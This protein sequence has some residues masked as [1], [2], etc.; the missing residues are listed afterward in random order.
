MGERNEAA[1][2]IQCFCRDS[3]VREKSD[4]A[5]NTISRLRHHLQAYARRVRD[6][7]NLPNVS[8]PSLPRQQL[9]PSSFHHAMD[10]REGASQP[11]CAVPFTAQGLT[12][13]KVPHRSNCAVPFTAQ[14]LTFEK[15][16]HSHNCAVPFTAQGLTFEKV[17][18]SRLVQCH[19]QLKGYCTD[20]HCCR[21]ADLVLAQCAEAISRH[22]PAR[23]HRWLRGDLNAREMT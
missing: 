17:P 19:S 5:G 1:T 8:P 20:G 13:E 21:A 3:R 11:P 15:V 12:F 6:S 2:E 14:R 23:Q 7:T 22:Q 4:S 9:L 16:P 10:L 18:H